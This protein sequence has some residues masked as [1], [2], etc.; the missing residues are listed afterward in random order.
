MNLFEQL[1]RENKKISKEENKQKKVI[2]SKV[3]RRRV[4]ALEISDND[5]YRYIDHI[6]SN[7]EGEA[8]ESAKEDLG[9]IA[10]ELGCKPEEVLISESDE[11]YD[12]VSN[13]YNEESSGVEAQGVSLSYGTLGDIKVVLTNEFGFGNTFINKKD[14]S[15]IKELSEPL[16]DEDD[17]PMGSLPTESERVWHTRFSKLPDEFDRGVNVRLGARHILTPEGYVKY[18]QAGYPEQMSMWVNY[19]IRNEN[20]VSDDTQKVLD[21]FNYKIVKDAQGN[22]KVAP[23]VTPISFIGN[24]TN[25]IIDRTSVKT[26]EFDYEEILVSGIKLEN[27][28]GYGPP[29]GMVTLSTYEDDDTVYTQYVLF[30]EDQSGE[31]SYKIVRTD[32]PGYRL[33]SVTKFGTLKKV[34]RDIRTKR[35]LFPEG[36]KINPHWKEGVEDLVPKVKE[37]DNQSRKTESRVRRRRVK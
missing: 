24:G 2:E 20:G 8:K 18:V 4:E 25:Q 16:D 36:S 3:R 19:E 15:K 30:G 1:M 23:R 35:D 22:Y 14:L 37:Y 17:R 7:L 34:E 11:V 33:E 9:T 28:H 12:S 26:S 32:V 5:F 29:L 31:M 21:N 13:L 10:K 27:F 6:E